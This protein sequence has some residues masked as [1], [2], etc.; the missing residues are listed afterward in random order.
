MNWKFP[1]ALFDVLC[2]LIFLTTS[3]SSTCDF[4]GGIKTEKRNEGHFQMKWKYTNFGMSGELWMFW[5]RV[6]LLPAISNSGKES[7][8]GIQ[9]GTTQRCTILQP[10]VGRLH[11]MATHT[12]AEYGNFQQLLH[13]WRSDNFVLSNW[14]C[15]TKCTQV[16]CT[17]LKIGI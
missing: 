8:I 2:R 16:L 11:Y 5:Q 12:V 17:K 9:F 7:S 6:M 10:C 1:S 3:A 14:K 15:T 4:L 13:F